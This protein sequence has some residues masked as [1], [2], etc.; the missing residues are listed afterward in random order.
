MKPISLSLLAVAALALA[1]CASE[2]KVELA[3]R[4]AVVEQATE[5]RA[6]ITETYAG[7]VHA[8]YESTLGFRIAGK[9]LTRDVDVG[10][11]VKRGQVLATLE[12]QDLQLQVDAARAALAAATADLSLA[13]AE[14]ER[15]G[16]LLARKYIS[17]ALYD[18][19][20]N[21]YKAAE[22]RLTQARSQLSVAQNQAAYTALRADAD[23]VVTS[24]QA[25]LGQV[26]A[27]GTPVIGL[28]HDGDREVLIS[29]PESRIAQFKVDLP[30][31]VEVW[32]ND[33][34]R[35]A[36]AVRE[37]SPEADPRTR[38]Y[39]VRVTLAER[40]APV[41]LGMTARVFLDAGDAPKAWMLPLSAL[42]EK[43]GQP[44]VWVLDPQS[45]RVHLESVELGSYREEGLA[46]LG[47]IESSDWVVTAG[48][49][50]LVEGQTVRPIDRENRPVVL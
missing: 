39:D 48:V 23:G 4:P 12:P 40:D 36:G 44:A 38:T 21:A 18:A 1:G 45:K 6:S 2:A 50:L 3:A 19:R 31:V 25:E 5:A 27:A 13:K 15:H 49:H 29:V 32:A 47:G 16:E 41:Q 46:L 20:Q 14:L 30:V 7:E 24:V 35:L 10:A 22:A 11:Q 43:D 42:Y 8:R 33:N 17:Q 9:L 28:A 26:V 37:L 34:A